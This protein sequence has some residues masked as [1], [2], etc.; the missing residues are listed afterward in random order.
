[1]LLGGRAARHVDDRGLDDE[2]DQR[3]HQDDEGYD[4]QHDE[5]RFVTNR[6]I[7]LQQIVLD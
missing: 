4:Q 7:G 6:Y 3:D 1:M 2:R 5:D